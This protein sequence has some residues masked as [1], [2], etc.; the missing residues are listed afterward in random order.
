M[1]YQFLTDTY[2]T[3]ILKTLSVWSM[4]D[5]AD[6]RRRP[7]AEDLR[8][9]NVLEHMVHQCV[10]EDFWFRTMLGIEVTGDPLPERETR[11][12]FMRVYER[13]SALRLSALGERTEEWWEEETAFFEV[14]RTRLWVMTRR[15]HRRY[16][17]TDDRSGANH[18]CL[19][20]SSRTPR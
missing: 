5:D 12:E 3:E 7:H 9:R 18:L 13:D 6:L 20:R 15:L 2:R 14:R 19:S 11:L 16:R 4:F 17:R 10:S 8:G 1:R